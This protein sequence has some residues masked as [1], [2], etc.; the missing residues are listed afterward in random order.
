[1]T[2]S[3]SL[4]S[5]FPAYSTPCNRRRSD[6]EAATSLVGAADLGGRGGDRR[7]DRGGGGRDDHL[8]PGGDRR[9]G[10]GSRGG[11]SCPAGAAARRGH[12]QTAHL[13]DRVPHHWVREGAE[14]RGGPRCAVRPG[15]RDGDEGQPGGGAGSVGRA[16]NPGRLLRGVPG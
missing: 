8:V 5:T 14:P 16:G 1:M 13:H 12:G 15:V 9:C 6:A 2:A 4:S 3:C 11:S 7:G 10:G